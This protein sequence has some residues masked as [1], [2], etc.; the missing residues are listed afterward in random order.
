MSHKGFTVSAVAAR[1][2]E[3]GRVQVPLASVAARSALEPGQPLRVLDPAGRPIG[4]AIADPE[5]DCVRLLARADE[6]VDAIDEAFVA[7]RV[8][9]A[10]DLRVTLG[11]TGDGRAY[12]L[13]NGSGD[14]LP[15]FAADVFASWAVLHVYARGLVSLGR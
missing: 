12:R 11:L 7:G 2:F 14:G 4:L 9:R 8:T 15:G 6:G 5:N 10:H 13:L 3:Q 1:E